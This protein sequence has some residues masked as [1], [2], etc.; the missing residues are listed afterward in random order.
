M[1]ECKHQAFSL[2]I[3][4]DTTQD[5]RLDDVLVV[6]VKLQSHLTEW[7]DDETSTCHRV[8]PVLSTHKAFSDELDVNPES[9]RIFQP[10]QINIKNSSSLNFAHVTHAAQ[11]VMGM[12][13]IIVKWEETTSP[14]LIERAHQEMEC[15]IWWQTQQTHHIPSSSANGIYCNHLRAS[16]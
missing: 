1:L 9:H 2:E 7:V 8:V 4:R 10:S 11:N 12:M 15:W 13:R 3:I 6:D 5:Y 14:R 16:G